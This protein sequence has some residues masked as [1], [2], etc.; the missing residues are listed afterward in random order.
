MSE[1][2]TS[3]ATTRTDRPNRRRRWIG[4]AAVAAAV[5]VGT[6]GGV[7]YANH[8][9][10]DVP[11][12]T[13]FHDAVGWA[14]DN[15]I[16][17]GVGGTNQFKPFDPTNRAEVV[18]FVHRYHEAFNRTETLFGQVSGGSVD[19]GV[20]VESASRPDTGEYLVTFD[21]DIEDC[22]L[23]A[24][25]YTAGGVGRIAGIWSVTGDTAEIH[26]AKHDGTLENGAFDITATC[27]TDA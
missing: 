5:S 11:D 26:I 23:N 4:A 8:S 18:T 21:R 19:A 27:A 24:T 15:G 20:G 25:T 2:T 6:V 17:T 22:A 16:T 9:F 7:A 13:Y 1:I 14:K 3:S 10:T 12:G